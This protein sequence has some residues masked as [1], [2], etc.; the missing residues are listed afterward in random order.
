MVV[1]PFFSDQPVNANCVEKFGVKK[2]RM[3]YKKKYKKTKELI[4]KSLGNGG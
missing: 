1:I 4:E 2:I 3:L